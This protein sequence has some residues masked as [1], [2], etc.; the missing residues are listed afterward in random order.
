[1]LITKIKLHNFKKYFHKDDF[2][3]N[4]RDK[5]GKIKPFIGVFGKNGAGK[6][7]IA[8]AITVAFT[9]TTYE[10]KEFKPSDLINESCFVELTL[11]IDGEA[12]VLKRQLENNGRAYSWKTYID[13]ILV[14][15]K[16]VLNKLLALGINGADDFWLAVHPLALIDDNVSK[17]TTKSQVVDKFYHLMQN[18]VAEEIAPLI[19]TLKD[20]KY[21]SPLTNKEELL[22]TNGEISALS[23]EP[24]AVLKMLTALNSETK[25]TLT[26]LKTLTDNYNL[27]KQEL[28]IL[29]DE[30]KQQILRTISE[31]ETRL[32]AERKLK[33]DYA[34]KLWSLKTL[35]K[36]IT[37]Q[38][39]FVESLK[40]GEIDVEETD[41]AKQ[42][43]AEKTKILT[44]TKKLETTIL[45]SALKPL[46]NLLK[47]E[48]TTVL[49]VYKQTKTALTSFKN[50]V[51][52]L[53]NTETNTITKSAQLE[54]AVNR[55]NELN[56][57]YADLNKSL[58]PAENDEIIAQ[59]ES[60]ISEL[61]AEINLNNFNL[62]KLT[63]LKNEISKE[64]QRQAQLIIAEHKKAYLT[65]V[66]TAILDLMTKFVNSNTQYA[67]IK[68]FSEKNGIFTS[69][70]QIYDKTS[71]LPF[72][73]LNK[74]QQWL[75]GV[76]LAKL[77]QNVLNAE[78]PLLID[79]AEAIDA[80]QRKALI[81][82]TVKTWKNHQLFIFVVK[83]AELTII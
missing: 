62:D 65:D 80:A 43:N 55:L 24:T 9:K 17:E 83:D 56:K 20:A 74:A 75:C 3:L 35:E 11:D 53:F 59:L 71:G 67:E 52:A 13:E 40:A 31:K 50:D 81:L 6:T 34:A 10:G 45:N 27:L 76:D 63:T 19:A 72:K 78:L 32:A 25:A 29:S 73:L 57:A 66:K 15:E 2:E 51:N 16:Q 77:F 18:A 5:N 64:K 61:R 68:L 46:A 79:G 1:M 26:Q 21:E 82:K 58:V 14:P 47:T 30:K 38:N 69:D 7:T 23:S 49:D 22:F 60:E 8:D 12:H 44:L 54:S 41:A 39:E 33:N 36:Q 70:F 28:N 37:A 4:L 42:E 48:K